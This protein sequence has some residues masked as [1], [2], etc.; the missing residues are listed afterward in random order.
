MHIIVVG[1]DHT[2][3]SIELREKLAC[4]LRQV[5]QVLRASQEVVQESVL[6]STCNRIE[7][8][9]VCQDAKQARIDLL[10]VLSEARQ[11]A[12]ADLEAHCYDFADGQA[13]AHL[14]GVASGLYS[15]V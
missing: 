10:H 1:V 5:P 3:A 2:T 9:A 7:L 13:I 11:V 4:S 8:Y 12:L 15:L 6:L 14:M